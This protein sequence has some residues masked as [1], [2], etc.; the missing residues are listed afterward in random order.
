VKKTRQLPSQLF[1]AFV[2]HAV[3]ATRGLAILVLLSTGISQGQSVDLIAPA[4]GNAI[5]AA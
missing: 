4:I 5:F 1:S 3:L 2:G